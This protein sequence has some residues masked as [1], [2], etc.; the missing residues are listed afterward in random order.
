MNICV[1]LRIKMEPGVQQDESPSSTAGSNILNSTTG[2]NG[3]IHQTNYHQDSGGP[4]GREKEIL[5]ANLWNSV[6]GKLGK[7]GTINTPDGECF[8]GFSLKQFKMIL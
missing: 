1:D 4:A 7:A 8:F 5:Q 6:T 3:S 2:S